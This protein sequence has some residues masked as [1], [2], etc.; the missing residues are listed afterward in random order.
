MMASVRVVRDG[1]GIAY[2]D[3]A[4]SLAAR[5]FSRFKRRTTNWM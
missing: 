1:D 4:D 2:K 3:L 5:P